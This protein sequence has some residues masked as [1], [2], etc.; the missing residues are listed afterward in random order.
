MCCSENYQS[1]FD[2]K[3]KEIF[4]STYKL[5]NHDISKFSDHNHDI[6]LSQKG[7]YPYEYT[8][9]WGKF[10]ETLSPEKRKFLQS[11]KYERYY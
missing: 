4:F 9:G 3:L 2:E 11:L 8:D 5:S 10:N 6:L 1:K 7:V